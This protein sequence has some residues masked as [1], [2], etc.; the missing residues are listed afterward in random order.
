MVNL[1]SGINRHMVLPPNN[2]II[3]IMRESEFQIANR[4]FNGQ[5]RILRKSGLDKSKKRKA[6]SKP[7]LKKMYDC[8]CANLENPLMLQYKVYLD[9]AFY[10]GHRGKEGLR[11]LRIDSFA[12]KFSPEGRKYIMMMHKE[13]IKST[14]EFSQVT[15]RI[16]IPMTTQTTSL[17][18]K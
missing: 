1:R 12:L 17:L 14:K 8:V 13:M 6:V 9:L 16:S 7:D 3:D 2:R 11:A 15:A 5:L 18:N 4:V 10:L